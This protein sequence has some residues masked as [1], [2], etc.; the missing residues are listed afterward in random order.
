MSVVGPQPVGPPS[1][2]DCSSELFSLRTR[3]IHSTALI[4][5]ALGYWKLVY[6]KKYKYQACLPIILDFDS[7]IASS[8]LTLYLKINIIKILPKEINSSK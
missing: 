4:S 1:I 7:L 6:L 2:Q 8:S 5:R 3:Q